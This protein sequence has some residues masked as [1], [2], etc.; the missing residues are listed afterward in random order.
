[1]N[2]SI[3]TY[4][5]L[6]SLLLCFIPAEARTDNTVTGSFSVGGNPII[7]LAV[8]EP[9]FTTLTLTWTSPQSSP[10]WGP[11]TQ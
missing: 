4:L 7:G 3:L 8:V 6:L 1:M 2:K 11:A 5:I 10:G 9:T